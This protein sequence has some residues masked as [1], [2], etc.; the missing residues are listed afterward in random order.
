[1]KVFK[2]IKNI[3]VYKFGAISPVLYEPGIRQNKYFRKLSKKGIEIPPGSGHIYYLQVSTYKG[4]LKKYNESGLEGLKEKTRSD[5]GC[6]RKLTSEIIQ[7]INQVMEKTEVASIKDLERKLLMKEYIKS[8]D[9]CYETLRKY[10]NDH[11]LLI[12]E[13]KMERKK[14][15]KEFVNDL[16]MVDFKEGKSIKFGRYRRRTY[17][18]GIID[19]CSRFLVGHQWGVNEDT[20]LFARTL[21][22]AIAIYGI[23]KILY[24]DQGKVFLS[25]YIVQVCAR[26]GISLVHAQPYSAASKGKIER[27]NGTISRMFYPLVEDFASLSIDQLNQQFSTFVN[28]IYHTKVHSTPGQSPREKFQTGLSK[29]TIRRMDENQLEQFFLCSIKRKVRLDATVRI[30][31]IY[32]EVDMKYV[33]ETVD[34]R[35]PIDQPHRFYLF[36]N[37]QLVRQ[38]KPV[39]LVENA[40]PPYVAT[41]YSKLFKNEK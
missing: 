19:D 36:E 13:V 10:V 14:F 3:E 6:H 4:W 9:I 22:R 35:F 31:N 16:W 32:Y 23:P 2:N 12:K 18:C 33:G 20:A 24:C 21:K 41:S 1:M 11:G 5:K 8:E 26:L 29:T 38:L 27:F 39:D 30:N 7:G 17:F 34:I 37:D 40:N 25:I 28:E 15:E